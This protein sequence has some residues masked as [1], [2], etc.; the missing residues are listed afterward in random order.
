MDDYMV[1]PFALKQMLA[2]LER[3]CGDP[4]R[5]KTGEKEKGDVTV[6]GPSE[7]KGPGHEGSSPI[8][9]SVLCGLQDLQVEGGPSLVKRVVDAY[10]TDSEPLISQLKEALSVNDGEALQRSAHSLKSSSANVGALR[11]SEISRE[12][13]MNC[14][15]NSLEDVAR[16][17]AAI[18]SEFMKA[19]E[20][21]QKENDSR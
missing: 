13:E 6:C 10:L 12:L 19:K 8:D 7:E 4:E 20:T 9:R 1:K 3:W 11:L 15:N 16:L 21:L 14:R 17:V 2:T 5:V 18:E